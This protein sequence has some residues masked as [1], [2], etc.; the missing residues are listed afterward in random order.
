MGVQ[1]DLGKPGDPLGLLSIKDFPREMEK[2]GPTSGERRAGN[3]F[4]LTP[5]KVKVKSP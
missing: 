3:K 5:E 1:R 4:D 2:N